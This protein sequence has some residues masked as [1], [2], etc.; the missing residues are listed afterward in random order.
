MQKT[1]LMEKA[2]LT[3]FFE[4]VVFLIV[5]F[6][7]GFFLVLR[8]GIFFAHDLHNEE[9]K[10]EIQRCFGLTHL[11]RERTDKAALIASRKIAFRL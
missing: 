8:L 4:L 2:R 1:S 11:L 9:V 5:N 3:T 7:F 6:L 10:D